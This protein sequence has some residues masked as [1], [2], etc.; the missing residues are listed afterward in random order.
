M[1][2]RVFAILD[3]VVVSDGLQDQI[4]LNLDKPSPF[5]KGTLT[6]RISAPIG[7]GVTWCKEH[8]QIEP[9]FKE[10]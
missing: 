8:F 7:M 10:C 5:G 2:L 6:V 4:L 1:D 3:A 9:K